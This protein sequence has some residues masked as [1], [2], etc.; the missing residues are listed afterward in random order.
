MKRFAQLF[1]G[2][3][4]VLV[5]VSCSSTENELNPPVSI[6]ALTSGEVCNQIREGFERSPMAAVLALGDC[7]E[8]VAEDGTKSLWVEAGD[9]RM[10]NPTLTVDEAKLLMVWFS[11]GL[12]SYGFRTAGISPLEFNTLTFRFRD[13]EGS[14]FQIA[15]VDLERMIPQEGTSQ[16]DWDALI[17]REVRALYSKV[18]ITT[19]Q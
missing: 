3:L 15:P 5:I 14:S 18:T 11:A 16:E 17:E 12:A 4:L 6:T 13:E 7:E 9:I 10:A 8:F 19:I 2:A 1:G